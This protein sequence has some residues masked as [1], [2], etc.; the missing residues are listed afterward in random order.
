MNDETN[1][2]ESGAA[3][4]STATSTTSG[5]IT[6]AADDKGTG[7]LLADETAGAAN[8]PATAEQATPNAAPAPA[9]PA[10]PESYTFTGGDMLD[11]KDIDAFSGFAKSAGLNQQQAQAVF[12]LGMAQNK[13]THEALAKQEQ[14]WRAQFLAETDIG[15]DNYLVTK[16]YALK[17]LSHYGDDGE[18]KALLDRSGYGSNPKV[19]RFLYNIGKKV[20]EDTPPNA[21]ISG[22]EELPLHERMYP[23]NK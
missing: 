21:G 22:K 11:A 18:I 3:A 12:D 16:E 8:D 1:S 7:S 15:G 20:S 23:S 19:L 10:V 6:D 4:E 2:T 14:T 13:A 9:V 5:T 17:A